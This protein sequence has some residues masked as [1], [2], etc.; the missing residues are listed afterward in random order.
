MIF[1]WCWL[2]YRGMY[3][4]GANRTLFMN[5]FLSECP[6][7]PIFLCIPISLDTLWLL[8]IRLSLVTRSS[9]HQH[10]NCSNICVFLRSPIL[11]RIHGCRPA[12]MPIY[13][14]HLVFYLFYGRFGHSRQPAA[15]IFWM[16]GCGPLLIPAN[17]FLVYTY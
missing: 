14:L 7:W 15:I 5:S 8:R 17:Q 10:A 9:E 11:D 2:L 4:V 16:R 6:R 3:C 12:S 1:R 13:V